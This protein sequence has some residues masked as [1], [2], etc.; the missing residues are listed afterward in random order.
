MGS[1]D[2]MLVGLLF[3]GS[4]G[5]AFLGAP[6]LEFLEDTC[7]YLLGGGLGLFM[8]GTMRLFDRKQRFVTKVATHELSGNKK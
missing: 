2:R 3:L 8:S 1:G 6:G 4:G 5:A 7:L